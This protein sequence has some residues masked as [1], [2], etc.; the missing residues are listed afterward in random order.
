M[1]VLPV[2]ISPTKITPLAVLSR[3]ARAAARTCWIGN[4]AT[5]TLLI[6]Q[7]AGRSHLA[8]SG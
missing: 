7:D 4:Q 6:G 3:A 2:P 1:A 5:F 8:Q